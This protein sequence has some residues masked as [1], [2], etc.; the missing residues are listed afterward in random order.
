MS[1]SKNLVFFVVVLALIM[2]MSVFFVV[3]QGQDAIVLRLGRLVETK[4]HQVKVLKPGLHMKMPVIE[5]IRIFDT[6]LQTLDIKSSRIVTKEKKDVIVSY[7]VKWK[8]QNLAKYFKATGGNS[9][10]AET[11]LEQQLNTSLRAQ[12]GKRSIT[13]VVSGGRDDIMEIL[14]QRAEIQAESLGVHVID[15]RIKGID[16]PESTTAAIYQ[17]MRADMQKIANHHRADGQAAGEAVKAGADAKVTIILAQAGKDA[18]LLKAEGDAS[19]S[20]IYANAYQQSPTF[21]SLYRRLKA[22]QQSFQPSNNMF[23][24]DTSSD[25]FALMHHGVR[26]S[27]GLAAAK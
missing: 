24:V 4:N 17:R 16:L 7:Y 25:F 15:V 6:R 18:A 11:L 26:P 13:E 20:T 10:K 23:V 5:Q 12:F 22:Y 1:R 3:R 21:F 2:M 9:F 14:R 27:N 19:A 8:I